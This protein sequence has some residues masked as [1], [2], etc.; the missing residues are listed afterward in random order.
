MRLKLTPEQ[1]R[2]S[3]KNRKLY[4]KKYYR[5]YYQKNKE[6]IKANQKKFYYES[7]ERERRIAERKI[8]RETE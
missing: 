5:N 4:A 3:I 7:G 1:K 2:E 6:K 8:R